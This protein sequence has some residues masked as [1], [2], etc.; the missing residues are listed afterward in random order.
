M[1]K[2][3]AYQLITILAT[4]ITITV[5]ALANSLPLN[6]LTTGEISDRFEIY[7]VPAGYVFSIWG[8]I[9]LGLI[10]YTVYQA[11]PAQKDNQALKR[12]APAY[13]IGSLANS[14]WIFL[15]HFEV[16]SL[17][18][19]A[20]LGILASLLY[21]Y[22]QLKNSKG[23]QKWLVKLPFSIY[24]GWITV[25]TVANTSQFL[26]YFNWGGWGIPGAVWAVIMI[27]V[28]SLL[29]LLMIWREND[30]PYLLVLVWAFIGITVSQA[31]TAIVT[32]A[33]WTAVAIL[34][35]GVLITLIKNRR[36]Y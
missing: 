15:W 28:A 18:L 2:I 7:F 25:A 20:M 16:F 6:G 8:L 27:A 5:N 23:S 30:T 29:G 1:K 10:L 26:F 4:L 34:G 3:S 31:S 19:I 11:L 21:I 13:W 12:I 24:L 14:I 32:T 35:I 17:T 22:L 36:V 33:S 9:Y